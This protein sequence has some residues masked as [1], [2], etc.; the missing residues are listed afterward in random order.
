MLDRLFNLLLWV[1]GLG[2]ALMF[3]FLA[4]GWSPLIPVIMQGV[5][6]FGVALGLFLIVLAGPRGYG[7][8]KRK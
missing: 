7:W 6:L 3:V 8:R 2:F 4:F 1:G 5:G